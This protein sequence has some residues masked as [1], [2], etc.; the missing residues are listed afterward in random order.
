MD[1]LRPRIWLPIGMFLAGA[2]VVAYAVATGQAEVSLVVIVPVFSGSS[3]VFLL[4]ILL[5]VGSFFLGFAVLATAP[6]EPAEVA[7]TQS[8]QKSTQQTRRET[9]YGGVVLIGPIPIAFGSNKNIARL[10]LVIGLVLAIAFV[11][12]LLLA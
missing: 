7:A 4:G 2:L 6:P 12:L 9:K 1:I 11:V 5:M 10:M 8:A 3:G